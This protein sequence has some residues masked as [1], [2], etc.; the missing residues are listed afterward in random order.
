MFPSLVPNSSSARAV[1]SV[2]KP[3]RCGAQLFKGQLHPLRFDCRPRLMPPAQR[4]WASS[5]SCWAELLSWQAAQKSTWLSVSCEN[6]SWP[7]STNLTSPPASFTALFAHI[8]KY[9]WPLSPSADRGLCSTLTRM[10]TKPFGDKKYSRS[11]NYLEQA[12][13]LRADFPLSLRGLKLYYGTK[14]V[15]APNAPVSLVCKMTV[16]F[17]SSRFHFGKTRGRLDFKCLY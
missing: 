7:L 15:I 3:L 5:P 1:S 4:C 16:I 8:M 2:L 11:A 9:P 13:H 6:N 17:G 14:S 10:C 12:P